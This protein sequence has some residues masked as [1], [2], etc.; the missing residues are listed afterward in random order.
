MFYCISFVIRANYFQNLLLRYFLLIYCKCV[1]QNTYN[2]CFIMIVN[3]DCTMIFKYNIYINSRLTAFICNEIWCR[4][5]WKCS[6]KIVCFLAIKFSSRLP[7]NLNYKKYQN[8]K[9]VIMTNELSQEHLSYTKIMP[10]VFFEL[11]NLL[12]IKLSILKNNSKYIFYNHF[13]MYN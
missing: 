1:L 9:K 5:N 10:R 3:V 11:W 13:S 8:C 12:A 7:C 4:W 6:R 2:Q